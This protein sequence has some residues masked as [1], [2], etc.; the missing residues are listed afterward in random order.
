[1][2]LVD[3]FYSI[4]SLLS[5]VVVNFGKFFLT[6]IGSLSNFVNLDIF[7]GANYFVEFTNFFV[8]RFLGFFVSVLGFDINNMCLLEVIPL[9][10]MLFALPI[11]TV[12]LMTIFIDFIFS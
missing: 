2:F 12:R 1:M 5:N 4:G 6:P 7:P 8:G 11:I 10:L 3:L 9:L